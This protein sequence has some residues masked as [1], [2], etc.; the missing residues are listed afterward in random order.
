MKIRLGFEFE[1]WKECRIFA[2]ARAFYFLGLG[3][4]DLVFFFFSN[5]RLDFPPFFVMNGSDEIDGGKPFHLHLFILF[6]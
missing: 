4:S 2:R 5:D 3:I 1:R 6:P